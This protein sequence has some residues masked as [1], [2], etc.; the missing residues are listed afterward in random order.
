MWNARPGVTVALGLIG[1]L[2]AGTSSVAWAGDDSDS[3][4][5]DVRV[6][7]VDCT[8]SNP[9]KHDS[10]ARAL[11]KKA[12]ELILEI[13]GICIEDF[14]IR[15]DSVTIRGKNQ[16]ADVDGIRG[17]APGAVLGGKGDEELGE[18]VVLVR[19]AVAVRLEH[20]FIGEGQANRSGVGA[21]DDSVVTISDCQ[22]ENNPLFGVVA[23]GSSTFFVED[24]L[25]TGNAGF[26]AVST[27]GSYLSVKD[28]VLIG[29]LLSVYSGQA[30]VSGGSL[31]GA[32]FSVVN[33]IVG[34]EET[35]HT[36]AFNLLAFD[37]SLRALSSTIQGLTVVTDFS[38]LVARNGSRIEGS[39]TCEAGGEA[40]CPN[41][42]TDVAV[43]SD[44]GQCLKP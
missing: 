28:S 4:S 25:V 12:D 43:T 27:G 31:S 24:S 22:V 15:R 35:A 30:N 42:A 17:A 34:L 36:G 1:C 7:A 9:K 8:D 3:D 19:G 41:P 33:S 26:A 13:D 38:T 29:G 20:L 44:C 23:A 16:N 5:D 2:V 32:I 11:R 10:I 6:A 14:V 18:S 21:V 37:S 40:Y 39:L